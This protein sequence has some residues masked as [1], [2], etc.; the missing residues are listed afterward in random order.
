MTHFRPENCIMSSVV[1]TRCLYAMLSHEKSVPEKRSGW[2]MPPP[3]SP[4]FK[5]YNLGYKVVQKLLL[6]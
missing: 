1:F 3:N 6:L 4:T 2:S 5:M